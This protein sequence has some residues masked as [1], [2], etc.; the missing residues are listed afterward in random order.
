MVNYNNTLFE[1]DFLTTFTIII[2]IIYVS[3]LYI[4]LGLFITYNL[5]RFVFHTSNKEF[6]IDYVNSTP[7]YILILNIIF[8]F[9]TIS[10]IAYLT[11]NIVQVIPFP[12]NFANIDYKSVR[13][14]YTGS[15][16]AIILIAFSQTLSTQYKEIKY[17]LNGKVY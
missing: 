5:D 4:I 16:L 6:S 3:I 2:A 13:E 7:T 12:F 8:T 10:L 9:C 15:I 17:K 1:Q 14:V 11:R